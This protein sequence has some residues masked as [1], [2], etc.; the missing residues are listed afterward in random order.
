[1][2]TKVYVLLVIFLSLVTACDKKDSETG[3]QETV[4]VSD[5]IIRLGTSSALTGHAGSLG[6]QYLQGA[7]VYFNE[8]NSQGGVAGRKIE[9]VALDDQ[10]NPTKTV[11]NTQKLINDEKV[12]ALFNY[13]G[14]PTS[15]AVKPIVHS[16]EIPLLGL[17]TGAE[18]LR[19]PLSRHIFHLRDSYY[20]E[21]EGAVHYFVD[22]L[23][24]KNIGVFYQEDAFGMAVL[25]GIQ[26]ALQKRNLEPVVTDT[27]VRGSIDIKESVER[28]NAENLD[29][30]M[31]VGTYSPLAKFIKMTHDLNRYPLFST[32][33]FVGSEAYANELVH[34]QRVGKEYYRD[35]M[36]TQVVPSPFSEKYGV[37]QEYL[38]LSKKYYPDHDANYVAFEGFLNARLVVV[39]LK[40]CGRNITRSGF[41]DKLEEIDNYDLGIDKKVSYGIDDREGIKGIYYSRLGLG[42]RFELF[43]A[44]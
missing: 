3:R 9:V 25:T 15:V 16:A 1:M 8:I 19:Q 27:Y 35:I 23:G 39:G 11:A 34:V 22:R 29:V 18:A 31:M 43:E 44:N 4:G 40:S 21:A 38:S 14:T 7:L 10:Y 32:V 26:I 20:S 17:F 5:T 37:A 30:I 13:V 12:F 28:I 36:V 41:I 24:L 2:R 42:G 6:S 33:S